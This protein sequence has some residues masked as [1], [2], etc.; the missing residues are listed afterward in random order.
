MYIGRLPR[1]FEVDADKIKPY[2]DRATEYYKNS[3]GHVK[4]LLEEIQWEFEA[5]KKLG[6]N[7]VSLA[8]DEVYFITKLMT[9][10]EMKK[11][12]IRTK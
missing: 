6:I 7:V 5:R 9:N 3:K 12:F 4:Y 8:H 2:L 1:A 10:E 11:D